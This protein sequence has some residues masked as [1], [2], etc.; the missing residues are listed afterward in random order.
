MEIGTAKG[1][2]KN[3]WFSNISEKI[4]V[5]FYQ[6]QD[7]CS[8]KVEKGNLPGQYAIKVTCTKEN[9]SNSFQVTVEGKK[10]EQKIS[11]VFNSGK[12]Y[13]LQ[14]VDVSK[15]NAVSD[16]YTWKI[17]PTNDDD[18]DFT[19]K[20]L[21]K[22]RNEIT[23]S[24]IGKNEITINSDKFGT[25]QT[26]YKLEYNESKNTY[27][28]IDNIKQAITKHVW[29]ITV[30]ESQ[31]K[32]TFVY[33]RLPGK[34]DV[35]KSSYTIDKKDYILNEG[36][37][38]EVT[39]RDR[40]EVNVASEE[41][42]LAKEETKTQVVTKDTKDNKYTSSVQKSTIQYTYTYTAIGKYELTVTYDGKQIGE[43][44]EIIVSYQTVDT[45]TSKLYFDKG[46]N[47]E[48]FMST[49]TETNIDNLH[50]TPFYKFYLYTSAGKR[51]TVYDKS[52]KVTCKMTMVANEDEKWE[53]DYCY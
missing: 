16:Q 34:V 17:K 25:T 13:Y 32:Y 45:K 52:V 20:L 53:L 28:L 3:Y 44:A 15:F 1:E 31:K 7:S 23:H 46:D 38:V 37:I 49:E 6:D 33:T 12:A 21:D 11:L 26:Y 43:K 27:T 47:K 22:N 40:Y 51:I 10:I 35:T 24:V 2:R 19:F 8:Y 4:K 48:T 18:I 29:T 39:L 30:V 50:Y 41:G 36:S 14:V 42:R 5:S 9:D